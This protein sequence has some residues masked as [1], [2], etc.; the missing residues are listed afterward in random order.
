MIWYYTR[1]KQNLLDFYV[2]FFVL[3]YQFY[4]KDYISF[5]F[6]ELVKYKFT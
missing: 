1:K 3:N 2:Y 5:N 6:I 4:Y